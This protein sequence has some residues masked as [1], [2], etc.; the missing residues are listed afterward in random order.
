VVSAAARAVGDAWAEARARTMLTHVHSVCGRFTEAEEE[1]KRAHALGTNVGDPVA[2]GQAPNQRGIIALYEGRHTDA[3]AHFERALEAFRAD[4]NQPGAASA[5]CNLSR[6][7]LAG[8]RT[9][10]AVALAHQGVEIYEQDVTGQALRLANGKYALGLALTSAGRTAEARTAL[11]AALEVFHKSRQLLWHGMTLF[12]LAELDL[13]DRVPASAASHAEQALAVLRGIGGDWRRANVLT[14]LGRAL[15][16]I[17][18]TDR[19]NVCW[20]DALA[21]FEELGSIEADEVRSLLH[22]AAVA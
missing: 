17:G 7:H 1:G 21:I 13:A 6:V 14:V 10:S 3:E 8:G 5:L 20:Q 9:E 19:A 22:P 12:R 16:A 2:S 18:H 4:G 15:M 11:L